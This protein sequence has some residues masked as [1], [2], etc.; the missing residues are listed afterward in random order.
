[1]KIGFI[2]EGY[3]PMSGGVA[4]SAQ[5]VAREFVKMGHEVTLLCFDGTTNLNVDDYLFHEVDQG[6]DVYR[7]GP[8]FLK[9]K[10]IPAD[11]VPEKYKAVLRRRAEA[12]MYRVLKKKNVDIIIT[13]YLM[14]A[15]YIGQVLANEFGVP[16]V[17]GVRGNDIGRN[18]YCESRFAM[19]QWVINSADA[20]V[21]VNQHLM[22][23]TN[24]IF[25]E[26]KNKVSVIHNG[27]NLPKNKSLPFNREGLCENYGWSKDDLIV[28][29]IGILREKK[30][31]VTLAKAIEKANENN[32]H[33]RLLVIGPDVTGVEKQLVGPLWKKL[34]NQNLIRVTGLI[35]RED[36]LSWAELADTV[37]IPSLDDG[38]A[39]GL[40][41]GMSLGLCPITTTILNDVV[42]DQENGLLVEPGD[43][44]ELVNA[45]EYV[46]NHRDIAKEFGRKSKEEIK[47]EYTPEAE[48]AKYIALFNK[49]LGR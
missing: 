18:I 26:A 12:Q 8:F 45:F 17:A 7:V 30:G 31:V 3:P 41:E 28:T 37:C 33:I 42:R 43:V 4:T 36:V 48:A 24:L 49:I 14:N 27:F 5:R 13:F 6:I 23:R 19:I 39:N 11:A 44:D 29:F 32:P 10:N 15:G 1:M 22:N 20:V 2:A 9:N 40:L 47:K 35:P 38:M 46:Y 16:C 34:C 21:C 25:K